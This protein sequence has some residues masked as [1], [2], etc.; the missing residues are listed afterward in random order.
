MYVWLVWFV[1][2]V[3]FAALLK[4][5][6]ALSAS[7]SISQE[8]LGDLKRA[9]EAVEAAGMK[10]GNSKVNVSKGKKKNHSSTVGKR[11]QQRPAA[12]I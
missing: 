11:M 1:Y 2:M 3:S 5:V 6:S 9:V 8:G 10:N 7:T 12:F 4:Q